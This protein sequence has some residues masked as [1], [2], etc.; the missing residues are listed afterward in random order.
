MSIVWRLGWL[1]S[2]LCV[3]V[4]KSVWGD[5]ER[6][7]HPGELLCKAT[8]WPSYLV[9][10]DAPFSSVSPFL[11]SIHKHLYARTRTH[12]QTH[13]CHMH[14]GMNVCVPVCWSTKGYF[15]P[16][17]LPFHFPA[18]SVMQSP[19][20]LQSGR[21]FPWERNMCVTGWCVQELALHTPQTLDVN[22][23]PCPSATQW[24]LARGAYRH[25]NLGIGNVRGGGFP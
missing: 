6:T 11:S 7:P 9:V 18:G 20:Q 21:R 3:V 8:G 1:V 14:D 19:W 25:G 17:L 16:P 2:I 10:Q 24:W 23:G 5:R 4:E 13:T 22:D 15:T 12:T